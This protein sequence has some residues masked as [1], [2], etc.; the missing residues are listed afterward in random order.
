MFDLSFI[1]HQNS[2]VDLTSDDIECVF[3]FREVLE[4]KSEHKIAN[5]H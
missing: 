5:F 1:L 2:V 3:L 4:S